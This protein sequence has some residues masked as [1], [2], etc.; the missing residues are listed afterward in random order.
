M[1][2][3]AALEQRLRVQDAELA[4]L[5]DQRFAAAL[6]IARLRGARLTLTTEPRQAAAGA[7]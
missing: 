6:E 2:T 4:Q 1:T 3:I 5:R 7:S